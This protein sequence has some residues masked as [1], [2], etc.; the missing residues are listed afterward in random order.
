MSN[1][2]SKVLATAAV[3]AVLVVAAAVSSGQDK[4]RG[5]TDTCLNAGCHADIVDRPVMH[6]PAAAQRCLDCHEYEDPGEHLFGLVTEKQELCWECHDLDFEDV[7]HAPVDDGDC[8]ECHD[9]HGSGHRLMLVKDP[10]RGLCLNCHEQDVSTLKYVHGPVVA[11][12]CDVCHAAHTSVEEKLLL[13]KP[14][15]LCFECHL[16]VSGPS[17]AELHR[18]KPIDDGCSTCHDPHQSD[19]RYQLSSAPPGL[20]FSCHDDVR[21]SMEGAAVI[22]GPAREDCTACHNPHFSVAANLLPSAGEE[23]CLGCHDKPIRTAAGRMLVNMAALLEANPLRH[24]PLR[25]GNCGACHTPHAGEHAGLLTE[26]YVPTFYAPFD[27]ERYELCFG[28]HDEDLV[29]D[30]SGTGFTG[31]RDGDRNLHWLHVNR[32]K[33]RTCRACHDVHA[34]SLPFHIRDAVPFGPAGWMLKVGYERT[35]DGGSCMPSC[36]GPKSY[37][38]GG[39]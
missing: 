30:E 15:E 10:S 25:E 16:D 37:R 11:G 4:P 1:V 21:E 7:V 18:H 35:A 28:C 23:L 26:A 29:D 24:G 27:Y 33:G 6:R 19:V 31:F 38:R 2:V 34:S 32:T 13:K 36:H 9:P 3:P 14:T 20:C 39:E 17:G 5:E 8:M 12:A 22:H